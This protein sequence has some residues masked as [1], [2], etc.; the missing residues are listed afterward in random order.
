MFVAGVAAV[1]L[2]LLGLPAGSGGPALRRTATALTAAGVLL[3]GTGVT[4]AGTGRLDAHGLVAIPALHRAADDRPVAYTPVCSHAV[5]PVCLHPAYAGRLGTVADALEPVLDEVAGLPGAPARISQA[6]AVYR[7][8]RGNGVA[9]SRAGPLITGF[10][11]TLHFLMPAPA[12]TGPELAAT[13]RA[14]TGRA[15]LTAVIGDQSGPGS[16]AVLAA[17]LNTAR[18]ESE[19]AVRRF[20]TLPAGTRRQWIAD[21]LAA[22]RAGRVGPAQLP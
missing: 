19:P 1:V 9:V 3:S 22:L 7:Q 4:L 13:V 18:P 15:I 2:G 8:E 14:D 16:S 6:P 21:H 20:A 5:I 11:P 12:L 17:L 10:P